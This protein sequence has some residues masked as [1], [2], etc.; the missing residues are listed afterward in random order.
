MIKS[1]VLLSGGMDSA[2]MFALAIG[3]SAETY[4]LAFDYGQRHLKENEFAKAQVEYWQKIKGPQIHDLKLLKVDLTQIGGS[5][6]T[7][8]TEVPKVEELKPGEIPITYVPARNTIF[9][10]LALGYAE[11]VGATE[12]YHGANVIDY[13]GYPDCRPEYFKALQYAFNLAT[14]MTVAVE[15]GGEGKFLTLHTPLVYMSKK[16]IVLLGETLDVPWQLTWSCYQGG[17]K[18]CGKCPSCVLR[19]KGFEEAG[20][21]DPLL[22]Q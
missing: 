5:A 16:E 19:L 9:L 20:V 14:K 21:N 8:S 6:L 15:T 7:S 17:E 12:L 3:D 4:P 18:A 22:Y 11:V 2:T 13:S 10:S 1:V